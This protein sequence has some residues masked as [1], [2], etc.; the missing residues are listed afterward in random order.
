MDEP[1]V[2]PMEWPRLLAWMRDHWHQGEH[3]AVIGPTGAGK[4]TF[5]AGLL[6][7]RRWVVV[8]D[9]KGGDRTW[10]ALGWPRVH[11]WPLPRR[12]Q[13]AVDEGRPVRL[14]LA[15]PL[16]EVGD[17]VMIR[18]VFRRCVE[19]AFAEGGWTLGVS[20]LQI[21]TDRR[22]MGLGAQLDTLLVA[23]RDRGVSV[24]SELQAPRW[25]SR[26]ATEQATYVALFYSR[27]LETADRLAEIVGRPKAEIRGAIRALQPHT[28]LLVSRDPRQP[29]IVTRP[30]RVGR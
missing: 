4:S 29:I 19:D 15:P 26:A 9:P 28:C 11:T 12:W 14:I 25:V 21:L 27:D 1:Q 2:I 22:M 13:A 8:L 17:V 6:G 18:E 23:A 30:H 16:R 24:V 7:L 3:V 20:E 10:K 5:D